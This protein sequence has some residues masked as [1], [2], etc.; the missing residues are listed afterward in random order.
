VVQR[1]PGQIVHETLSQKHPS[2]KRAGGTAQVVEC[3]PGKGEALKSNTNT[4]K[5]KRRRR[6]KEN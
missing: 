1:K 6:K 3:L 4:A 2:Q 5:K